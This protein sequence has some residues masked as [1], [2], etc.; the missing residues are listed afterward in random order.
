M[1]VFRSGA[2]QS[3]FMQKILAYDD[4]V[5][6]QTFRAHL[7]LPNLLILTITTGQEHIH[8]LVAGIRI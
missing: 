4:I 3:S 6:R 2:G 5:R 8:R 1:S 7:N